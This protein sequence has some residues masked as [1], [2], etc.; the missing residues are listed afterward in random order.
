MYDLLKLSDEE[1]LK[2]A[3][4]LAVGYAQKRVIRYGTKRQD[5]L[6]AESDAEHVFG[7]IYLA[8]YFLMHEPS[9][10]SLD[11]QKV[12]EILLFHDFPEIKH[13][14][15]VTYAKTAND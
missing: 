15:V 1:I 6:H 4:Q 11:K 10:K 13:G 8:Q 7:L 12:M 14:D 2:E 5:E 9:A 3:K